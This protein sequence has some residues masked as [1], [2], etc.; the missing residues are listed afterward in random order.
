MVHWDFRTLLI[1][2]AM[3]ASGRNTD[4]IIFY[5]RLGRFWRKANPGVM[6]VVSEL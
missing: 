6:P 1:R 4:I 5:P 3:S 2:R